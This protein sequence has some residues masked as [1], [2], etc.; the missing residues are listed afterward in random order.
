MTRTVRRRQRWGQ[1][2]LR[3]EPQAAATSPQL[4]R[5][6]CARASRFPRAT[7]SPASGGRLFAASDREWP[8]GWYLFADDDGTIEPVRVEVFAPFTNE[9]ILP[10]EQDEN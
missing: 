10:Q 4:R 3:G 7:A 6:P 5:A 8:E 1:R 9:P 2:G